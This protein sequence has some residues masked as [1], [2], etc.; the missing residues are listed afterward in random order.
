MHDIQK[1]VG[2][3]NI[4][5]SQREQ[6]IRDAFISGLPADLGPIKSASPGELLQAATYFEQICK[7][8]QQFNST[9]PSPAKVFKTDLPSQPSHMSSNDTSYPTRP[10]MNS[11][12]YCC[13]ERG[14]FRRDCPYLPQAFC[15]RCNQ[16]GH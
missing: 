11:M 2:K 3:L 10:N 5:P 14:H 7:K 16:K 6:Y 15:L 4:Y 9:I 1:L 12:C 8:Y 13:I